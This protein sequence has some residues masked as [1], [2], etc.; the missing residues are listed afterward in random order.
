MKEPNGN[1]SVPDDVSNSGPVSGLELW[2]RAAVP[3]VDSER[4]QAWQTAAGG[5]TFA[6]LMMVGAARPETAFTVSAFLLIVSI[7][8]VSC[9]LA[10]WAIRGVDID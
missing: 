5:V 1:N 10:S 4:P 8:L 2:A 3:F 9:E 7:L 6:G